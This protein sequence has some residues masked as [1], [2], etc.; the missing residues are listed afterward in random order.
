MGGYFTSSQIFNLTLLLLGAAF[1]LRLNTRSI[2]K[3]HNKFLKEYEENQY[4]DL[5]NLS[6]YITELAH[7][8]AAN[9]L[10]YFYL[11]LIAIVLVNLYMQ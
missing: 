9:A 11:T 8:Q 4:R 6:H 1:V 3:I 2:N 7:L 10:N 5:S